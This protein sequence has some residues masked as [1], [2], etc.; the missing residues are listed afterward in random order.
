[1]CGFVLINFSRFSIEFKFI[2]KRIKDKKIEIKNFQTLPNPFKLSQF[3]LSTFISTRIMKSRVF[4]DYGTMIALL[5]YM[6]TKTFFL[7]SSSPL[8]TLNKKQFSLASFSFFLSS[9][10]HIKEHYFKMSLT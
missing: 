7:L 1:M 6:H 8:S 2:S 5:F 9:A 3:S 4:W 10:E